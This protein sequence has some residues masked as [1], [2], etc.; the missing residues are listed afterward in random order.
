M[1]FVN[2]S[3]LHSYLFFHCLGSHH[4]GYWSGIVCANCRPIYVPDAFERSSWYYKGHVYHS[5]MGSLVIWVIHICWL[6][7]GPEGERFQRNSFTIQF[8]DY[9]CFQH[10]TIQ[11]TFT[12]HIYLRVGDIE[13]AWLTKSV[14]PNTLI[15]SDCNTFPAD[16]RTTFHTGATF[17]A[18]IVY[19]Y[20]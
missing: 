5:I 20:M 17:L 10:M 19:Y 1:V 13:R 16:T 4:D 2:H 12:H 18:S 3:F 8:P 6:A 9:T 14:V 11:S 7:S 15:Q